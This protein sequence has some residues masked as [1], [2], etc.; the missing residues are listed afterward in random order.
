M[1]DDHSQL[2]EEAIAAFGVSLSR[3][4]GGYEADPDKRRDLLQEIHIG[5]W[6]S[7]STFDGR[8]SLR[9]WVYRVAHNLAAS[10]IVRSRRMSSRLVELEALE[11]EPHSSDGEAAANRRHSVARLLDLIQKLAP[12]DRQVILLY[13]EGEQATFIAEVTGLSATHVATKIHRIKKVLSQQFQ[14]GEIY[15]KR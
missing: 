1:K 9:T 6:R 8:C 11:A 12:L 4:A 13:L 5:L 2:Y 7:L 3:L 14:D 15:A 10:H